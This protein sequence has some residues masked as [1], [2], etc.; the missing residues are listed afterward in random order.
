[1]SNSFVSSGI[2]KEKMAVNGYQEINNNIFSSVFSPWGV[3]GAGLVH[4][5]ANDLMRSGLNFSSGALGGK[6]LIRKMLTPLPV[7]T[8]GGVVINDHCSY[9]F[10]LELGKEDSGKVYCHLGSTFGRESYF[11]R[12]QDEGFTIVVLSNI[13]DYKVTDAAE[14]LLNIR[15]VMDN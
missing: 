15:K 1:M 2:A 3:V 12:S 5:S 14:K 9:C 10:G 7:L 6:G 8:D 4:S 11:L 13:E